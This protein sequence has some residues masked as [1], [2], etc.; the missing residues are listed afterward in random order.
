MPCFVNYFRDVVHAFI[1]AASSADQIM[2][3]KNHA[4]WPTG[5]IVKKTLGVM[6]VILR[7]MTDPA[8]HYWCGGGDGGGGGGSGP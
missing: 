3:I 6:I 5:D 1:I 4:P 8:V 7:S 2:E